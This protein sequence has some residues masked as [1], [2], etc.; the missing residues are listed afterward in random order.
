MSLPPDFLHELKNRFSGDLRLDAASKYLYS[1]DASLYQIEPLG[2]AIPKS[3]DDLQAAVELSAKYKIPILPRGSGTSLAGQ[4]I[5]EALV[6][7]CSR[8]LDSIIEID[9]ESR[10]ALVEPGVILS[11]LNRAA[12]KYNLMFGPDPASAE[13]ATMGGVIGNNATGAHSIIY[14]MSA[15]HLLEADVI[16][17]DG[18]LS[19]WGIVN[20]GAGEKKRKDGVMQEVFEVASIIREQYSDT[21]RRNYP[22]TWRNSAG[23]RLNYLLP[24]SPS[25]PPQ[26]VGEYPNLTPGTWNLAP[27][28]AGSE[29]TLAVIRRMKVNLVSKPKHTILGVLAYDSIVSACEDVPRL[30]ELNPSAIELIPQLI[31]KLARGVPAFSREMN[32]IQGDPAAILVVEFSGDNQSKLRERAVRIGQLIAL[33]ETK[34]EQARVWNVRKMGLGILDSR[35]NMARPAAFI[36]DCAVPVERLGEFVREAERILADHNTDAGIYAHASGGCLHIRPILN[37]QSGDGIRKLRSISAQVFELVMSLGGSM[38]SEHGDG[39]ARGEW[40]EKTYGVEI[41]D[42]MR[43][44]KQAADPYNLL[45]PRKMFE[46]PPMDTHLRYGENYLEKPWPSSLTFTHERGLAGAIEQCNGQGVCR[47]D[48]GVMCPSFQATRDEANSTRGRANLLRGL[49]GN[50]KLANSNYGDNSLADS[51]FQALDL[52]LACKGCTSECPSGVDMPRLKYEFMN[53]YYKSHRRP[54]HDYLFGYFHVLAKWLSPISLVVNPVMKMNWSQKLIASVA[55]ISLNREFPQFAKRN[56]SNYDKARHG[57]NGVIVLLSDVFSRYLEPE[58]E[59]A[60]IEILTQLGYEVKILNTTG[61]GASLLSKG[62]IKPAQRHAEKV[63]AEIKALGIESIVGVVGAEPPEIYCVKHEYE[64]LLPNRATELKI[65]KKKTWLIDEFILRVA[66]AGKLDSFLP[67]DINPAHLTFQPHCHQRA[68][69]MAEDGLP[70]G[71]S[72]TVEMLKMFGFDVDVI[73]AGC[74]GMAGTFG[75]D[76]EHYE[77]SMQV[78]ELGVLPKIRNSTLGTMNVVSTGAA[79]RMQIKHG[80]GVDAVHPLVLVRERLISNKR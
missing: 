32:W 69:A 40:I 30:L 47:K 28:L 63:L 45:N 57:G 37:L 33:A 5:G 17:S 18:S 34:E 4:V 15:D 46:A 29:G 25:K 16:L 8:Y 48:T 22:R 70:S 31:L 41:S 35:P 62:F 66:N 11:K 73:D 49:I 52:C 27:L 74:C 65:I 24:W 12:S 9:P 50:N 23:Y 76:A 71:T 10:S 14:G 56:N 80:T 7:D 53:E 44:L 20:D 6:F 58:V 36:E 75:F 67:S 54:L 21:I 19:K 51:A 42:A 61:S 59:S 38:S 3:Q 26:W 77:L 79:C 78:G 72:A 39:I 43:K 64:A 2:V 1:T 68:E 55:G 60:A 13:R